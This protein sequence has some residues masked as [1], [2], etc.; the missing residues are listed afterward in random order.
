MRLDTE[1]HNH[2]SR[3]PVRDDARSRDP[4]WR[5]ENYA[6]RP[7]LCCSDRPNHAKTIRTEDGRRIIFSSFAFRSSWPGYRLPSSLLP[8][9]FVQYSPAGDRPGTATLVQ[10][11]IKPIRARNNGTMVL[12]TFLYRSPT[13]PRVLGGPLSTSR[14]LRLRLGRRV[15][16]RVQRVRAAWMN[17]SS[18][19]DKNLVRIGEPE[20]PTL[21][22]NRAT[23]IQVLT[24]SYAI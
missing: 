2:K 18:K 10:Q 14:P 8:P 16:E 21:R 23:S 11:I 7:P 5:K 20:L 1:N 17:C 3:A 4:A 9:Q 13:T 22:P 6:V 24:I 12:D 15:W 19:T